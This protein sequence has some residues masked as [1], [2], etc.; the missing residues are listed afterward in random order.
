LGPRRKQDLRDDEIE[1]LSL[2]SAEFQ[3]FV[4]R[5]GGVDVRQEWQR[6]RKLL[7]NRI[8]AARSAVRK[9]KSIEEMGAQAATTEFYKRIAAAL[10]VQSE[11]MRRLLE[12]KTESARLSDMATDY[13]LSMQKNSRSEKGHKPT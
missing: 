8:S 1:F 9:K 3:K 11:Q 12:H 7:M 6:K 10:S 5:Q 2:P 13:H 4:A